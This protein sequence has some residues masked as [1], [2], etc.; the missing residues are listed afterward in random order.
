MGQP[1]WFDAI[2]IGAIVFVPRWIFGRA[3]PR[4]FIEGTPDEADA[5]RQTLILVN[6]VK[7]WSWLGILLPLWLWT[8]RPW[9]ALDHPK[10]RPGARG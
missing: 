10:P 6:A 9:S 1:Q 4:R 7:Q 2:V 5:L 8:R 3:V